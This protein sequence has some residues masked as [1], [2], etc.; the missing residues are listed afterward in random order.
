MRPPLF[1]RRESGPTAG[2]FPFMGLSSPYS[3]LFLVDKRLLDKPLCGS[4][5]FFERV[6]LTGQNL[7]CFQVRQKLPCP[8]SLDLEM[9]FVDVMRN[10]CEDTLRQDIL[11]PTVQVLAEA[12][13]LFYDCK[14][15]LRLYAPVH[16]EL[17]SVFC[18]DPLKGLLSF[19]VHDL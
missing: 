13:I 8:T 12:H 19:P 2:L 1:N 15:S 16:P 9:Q 5:A 3:L 6:V 7:S 4:S 14:A 11:F 17:C 18:R 10:S